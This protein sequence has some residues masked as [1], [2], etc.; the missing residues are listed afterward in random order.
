VTE[1]ACPVCQEAIPPRLPG[2]GRNRTYCGPR[3]RMEAQRQRYR[4]DMDAREAARRAEW[5]A[6]WDRLQGDWY[7]TCPVCGDPLPPSKTRPR[8]FCSAKCK[9][10]AHETRLAIEALDSEPGT[11]EGAASSGPAG[12]DG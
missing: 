12:L 4:A 5:R 8:K 11:L 6:K 2:P 1:T 3:C 7:G 9:Q 10:M